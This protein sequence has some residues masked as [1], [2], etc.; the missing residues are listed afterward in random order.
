MKT[1]RLKPFLIGFVLMSL[2]MTGVTALSVFLL[3][4]QVRSESEHEHNVTDTLVDSLGEAKLQVVQIQQYLTDS[5]ATGEQDGVDDARKALTAVEEAA[6]RISQLDPRLQNDTRHL[7]ERAEM[8]FATGLHMVDAYQNSR[9]AGNAIMKGSD[10]FDNQSDA[11]QQVIDTLSQNINQQQTQTTAK[12]E[13]LLNLTIIVCVTLSLLMAAGALVVGRL[14]YQKVFA[15]LG[16]EP[17]TGV[18]ISSR[19]ASGDLSIQV[20]LQDG[21][22]TSLL[23]QL[24]HMRNRWTEVASSLNGQVWL[25]LN[26][27]SQLREQSAL[28]SGHCMDQKDATIAIA[29]NI[30]E[31]SVSAK[32][33]A[34]RSSEAS[35]QSERSGE[36]SDHGRQIV[37]NMATEMQKAQAAVQQSV[38][39]VQVLNGRASEIAAL[40][41]TIQTISGQTNLLALNAAIEAAR[42][43]ESG[44]GFAVVADEV[45]S[46]ANSTTKATADI[47][48]IIN[49]IQKTTQ[50]IVSAIESNATH[51]Q[52]GL[53]LSAEAQNA[54]ASIRS[55]SIRASEQVGV[56]N[57]ALI[58]QQG[59]MADIQEKIEAIAR[60]SENNSQAAVNISSAAA[61]LDQVAQAV[62]NEVGYF[63]FP[64][65]KEDDSA[66]F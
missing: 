48:G 1:Q 17:A 14:L 36:T 65:Q 31:L 15:L 41:S 63:K 28:M 9:E 30:E 32:Q 25:M 20:Q 3:L 55:D 23:A 8:L 4:N 66:L 21:D 56:I 39:L 5:A 18:E 13:N 38:Q 22:K 42:A 46:L 16:G 12:V 33:I 27:F 35:E 47:T 52:N 51:V 6:Q 60:M 64:E 29:A 58:E 40:I 57:Y 49:D 7:L 62:K 2:V 59:A 53:G 50:D 24:G 26:A 37:E 19:L 61:S 43:G 10:G 54:I 44:R 11:L 45:R 34:E